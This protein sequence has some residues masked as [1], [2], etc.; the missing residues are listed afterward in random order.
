MLLSFFVERV[1][2]RTDCAGFLRAVEVSALRALH[3]VAFGGVEPYSVALGALVDVNVDS[4]SLQ[5]RTP[6]RIAFLPELEFFV[7]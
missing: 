4:V 6:H 5:E 7:A 1:I 3:H 2:H